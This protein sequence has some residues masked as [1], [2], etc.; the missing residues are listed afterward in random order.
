MTL[1]ISGIPV[2]ISKRNIKNMR[3]YVKPPNGDVMVSAPLSMSDDVIVKFVR[4]KTSWIK[5]Q[6]DKINNQPCQS[7]REYV[8]GETLNVWG[9][10]YNLQVKI[11]KKNSFILSGDTAILTTRKKSTIDQRKKTVHEWYRKLLKAEITRLLPKW[12][13]KTN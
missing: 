12:E 5:K 8:S 3:L 7:K 13:M 10:Q 1:N 2:E 6:V 11:G 9:K 4:S